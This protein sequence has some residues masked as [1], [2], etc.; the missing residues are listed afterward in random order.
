[1]TSKRIVVATRKG[2]CGK[3]T[4]AVH[5]A[6]T[7]A[8]SGK[9]VLLVDVDPQG[10]A[11]RRL[12]GSEEVDKRG[13]KNTSV[14]IISGF[15]TTLQDAVALTSIKNLWLLPSHDEMERHAYPAL[16]SEKGTWNRLK[17]E[18]DLNLPPECEYVIFDTPPSS[19]SLPTINAIAAA[20]YSLS[21]IIPEVS[22]AEQ[23]GSEAE[24]CAL[25]QTQFIGFVLTMVQKN[26]EHDHVIKEVR[27]QFGQEV[28]ET[29]IPR[30]TTISRSMSEST[31]ISTPHYQQLAG[32][33]I[34]R[35]SATTYRAAAA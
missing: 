2:G 6:V 21:P 34:G 15:G 3:T 16:E 11:S 33:L 32:E 28:F 9:Q 8:T 17:T 10:S 7:L 26:R 18:L 35:I 22:C 4:T 31:Q 19:L 13:A 27:S 5:L 24:I 30:A 1:M 25:T 12:L 14:G 29:I 20:D 23:M